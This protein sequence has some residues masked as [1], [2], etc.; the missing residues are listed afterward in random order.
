MHSAM[1][2]PLNLAGKSHIM[3]DYAHGFNVKNR[4]IVCDRVE[5]L[6]KNPDVL[7]AWIPSDTFG[8]IELIKK[9]V[10][11]GSRGEQ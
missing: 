3:L 7:W 9:P 1:D 8:G 4:D 2:C 10:V 5:T 6:M 11:G